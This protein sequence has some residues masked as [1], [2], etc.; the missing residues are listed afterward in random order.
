VLAA[1]AAYREDMDPIGRFAADCVAIA[2]DRK[3]GARAMYEAY[4]SWAKANAVYVQSETKFGREMRKRFTRDDKRTRSYLGCY[5]HDVPARPDDGHFGA[6]TPD[7][8]EDYA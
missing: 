5:L 8:V 4:V 2:A 6:P 1:T 7:G 3:V